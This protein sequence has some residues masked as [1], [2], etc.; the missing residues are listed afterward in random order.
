MRTKH[1]V[2]CS[3]HIYPNLGIPTA[4]G[5]SKQILLLSNPASFPRRQ[6]GIQWPIVRRQNHR[7]ILCQ[8]IQ[9]PTVGLTKMTICRSQGPKLTPP[10]QSLARRA[11]AIVSVTLFSLH[12]KPK[13]QKTLGVYWELMFIQWLEDILFS[14]LYAFVFASWFHAV[15]CLISLLTYPQRSSIR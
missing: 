14:I 7:P 10:A 4:R 2:S 15:Q 11:R 5:C 13:P 12:Y 8:V 6:N 1:I 3:Y 9:G